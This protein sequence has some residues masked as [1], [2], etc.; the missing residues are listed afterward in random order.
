MKILDIWDW[1]RL[2]TTYGIWLWIMINWIC[3]A[4]CIGHLRPNKN[5]SSIGIF[6]LQAFGTRKD[7]FREIFLPDSDYSEPW[8]T[9]QTTL[10]PRSTLSINRFLFINI[11]SVIKWNQN[12]LV[13]VSAFRILNQFIKKLSVFSFIVITNFSFT[14]ILLLLVWNNIVL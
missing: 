12:L 14:N 13:A 1:K 4:V 9:C 7:R 11:C 8:I 6:G 10:S 5:W 2:P 3:W